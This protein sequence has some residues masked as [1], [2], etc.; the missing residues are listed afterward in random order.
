MGISSSHHSAT[1]QSK[2]FG[3]SSSSSSLAQ[4]TPS[5][6]DYD[7]F[8]PHRVYT[9]IRLGNVDHCGNRGIFAT[10][11]IPKDALIAELR[12]MFAYAIGKKQAGADIM[13]ELAQEISLFPTLLKAMEAMEGLGKEMKEEPS[14]K[15]VMTKAIDIVDRHVRL[16]SVDG[17]TSP[18]PV[19]VVMDRLRKLIAQCGQLFPRNQSELV[20]RLKDIQKVRPQLL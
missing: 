7:P 17:L 10:T 3:F 12:P 20:Q 18:L 6:N 15:A 19:P 11:A 8:P 5:K 14:L 4:H 16:P 1:P 13:Q 9:S 2:R